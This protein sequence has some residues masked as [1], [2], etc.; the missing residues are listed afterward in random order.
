[1][2]PHNFNKIVVEEKG[3]K[4]LLNRTIV[5]GVSVGTTFAVSG[6]QG[7]FEVLFF[8]RDSIFPSLLLACCKNKK[9][10]TPLL[11]SPGVIRMWRGDI[12]FEKPVQQEVEKEI[13]RHRRPKQV[14]QKQARG[15]F[16]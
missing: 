12:E 7:T 3:G 4:P 16:Y 11:V 10:G 8:Y 9:T 2:I 5:E 13:I 6:L 15:L 1:M 14:E